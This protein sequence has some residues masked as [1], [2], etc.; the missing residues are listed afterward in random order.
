MR[1]KVRDLS[2]AVLGGVFCVG[3]AI[4]APFAPFADDSDLSGGALWTAQTVRLVAP[5][6]K[7]DRVETAAL[8][9]QLL[10]E[11][12]REIH[13]IATPVQGLRFSGKGLLQ[14]ATDGDGKAF[15]PPVCDGTSRSS[16]ALRAALK[17]PHFSVKAA[18]GR[19][20]AVSVDV[21][22]SG[23]LKVI[24]KEDSDGGQA[25]G[26][27][28]IA[29]RAKQ[30]LKQS[31][32]LGFWNSSLDFI[33]PEQADYYNF[34]QVHISRG[35]HWDVVGHEMGHGI[36]DLG[37]MGQFGGGEHKIDECYSET[38]AL[39]EGWASYFSAWVSVSLDDADAKFEYMVPRR[40]PLRFE[41]IP[42]DVCV[43]PSNEW[44]VTGFFWDLIDLHA[45][46]ETSTEAFARVWNAVSGK[47]SDSTVD[48]AAHLK[49]AGFDA[50]AVDLAWSLNF[51]H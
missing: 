19:D 44:R 24:F 13:G 4:A 2:F 12:L 11:V 27:W 38:L 31:V 35:D 21:P 17:D 14:R 50:A 20:Y 36:Y 28:Q 7:P 25:L 46:G 30:M 1:L 41:A 22:C 18:G 5:E 40:A 37:K 39:S 48:A 23:H 9:G 15:W 16:V 34:G 3:A 42:A 49:R 47:G 29:S 43:G 26:I 8:E 6:F 33:W 32:G 51:Q 10:I 45:D